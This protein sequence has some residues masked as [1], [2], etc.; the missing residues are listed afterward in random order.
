M[1]GEFRAALEKEMATHSSVLAWRIPGMGEPGGLPSMGSHRVGHDWSDLAAGAVFSTLK[2]EKKKEV[3]RRAPECLAPQSAVVWRAVRLEQAVEGALRLPW[4]QFR[5]GSGMAKV[6]KRGLESIHSWASRGTFEQNFKQK[7]ETFQVKSSGHSNRGV[8][9]GNVTP[10]CEFSLGNPERPQ[11][12]QPPKGGWSSGRQQRVGYLGPRMLVA[13]FPFWLW[14]AHGLAMY[15]SPCPSLQVFARAGP[16]TWCSSSIVL[17]VYGPWSS[18][19]WK[20]LS[21]K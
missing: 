1:E 18:P 14:S 13:T 17:V 15:C 6:P 9:W 10:L 21:R 4:V 11:C 5:Q 3:T 16:W 19:K 8:L 20:P 12:F 7:D 2:V